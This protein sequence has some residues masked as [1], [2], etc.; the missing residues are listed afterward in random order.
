MI[1]V[2]LEIKMEQFND[3]LVHSSDFIG[4]L[5]ELEGSRQPL[6]CNRINKLMNL[7]WFHPEELFRQQRQELSLNIEN[8]DMKYKTA[9]KVFV[10]LPDTLLVVRFCILLSTKMK[11]RRPAQQKAANILA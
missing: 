1:L 4:F 5:L 2:A 8:A 10:R 9:A 11:Y 6:P 7:V 3:F